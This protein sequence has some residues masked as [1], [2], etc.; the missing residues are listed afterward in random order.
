MDALE[1][2]L[3]GSNSNSSLF[4]PAEIF[5]PLMPFVIIISVVSVIIAILYVI[6]LVTTF[7]SHRATIETRDIL[8]EMN[9][10]DKAQLPSTESNA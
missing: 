7:R 6:N 3:G 4:N 10:R 1:S 8:R 9:E 2:L 5:A